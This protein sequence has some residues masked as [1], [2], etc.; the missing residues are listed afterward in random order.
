M[1]HVAGKVDIRKLAG[2]AGGYI[3]NYNRQKGYGVGQRKYLKDQAQKLGID[4]N[5]LAIHMP[6]LFTS[7]AEE[8]RH[9]FPR[10]QKE[11]LNSFIRQFDGGYAGGYIPN[12]F[13]KYS[14]E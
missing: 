10:D 6:D 7:L 11:Q 3:P 13:N 2:L 14:K 4:V 12:Y 8:F 1:I 5:D 9:R